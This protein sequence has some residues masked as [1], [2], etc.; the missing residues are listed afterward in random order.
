MAVPCEVGGHPGPCRHPSGWDHDHPRARCGVA[1]TERDAAFASRRVGNGPRFLWCHRKVDWLTTQTCTYPSIGSDSPPPPEPNDPR[2]GGDGANGTSGAGGVGG[3]GNGPCIG[4]HNPPCS[5]GQNTTSSGGGAGGGAGGG[6][7]GG[8][9]GGGGGGGSSFAAATVTFATL[10]A[11]ANTGTI[12]GGAAA[13]VSGGQPAAATHCA[14][15]TAAGSQAHAIRIPAINVSAPVNSVGLNPD[16]TVEVPQPGP[17]Y[18]QPAWYRYSPTPGEIGP[19]VIIG[20]VDSAKG[21]PSVFFE[22]G[23]QAWTADSG[24]PHRRQHG[25]LR[26]RP[27]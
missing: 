22:L 27:R 17:H 18:N 12:N 15:R 16:H 26:G 9:A 24:G 11:G 13:V 20:H 19:S 6:Y 3:V 10:T 5:G 23:A 1:A 25:G 7:F 2:F 8:G 21:G 14:V 4:T